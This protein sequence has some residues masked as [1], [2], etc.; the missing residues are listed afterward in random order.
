MQNNLKMEQLFFILKKLQKIK[1]KIS[2]V[3]SV[4]ARSFLNL[5]KVLFYFPVVFP[6]QEAI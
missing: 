6:P 1:T 3:M 5:M 2:S 4:H